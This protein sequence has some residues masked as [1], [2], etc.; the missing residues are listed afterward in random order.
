MELFASLAR[1]KSFTKLNLQHAYQQLTLEESSKPLTTINTHRGLFH[2]NRLPFGVSSTPGI[3]QRTMDSL[4]QGLSHVTVYLDDIL[5]TGETEEQHLEN[6]ETVLH[7]LETAGLRLK[8]F[9]CTFMAPEIEYLGHKISP[10]GLY[11]TP[12]NIKAIC[13]APKPESVSE[14]KSF[15]GLLSYY[16]WFLPNASS[17]LTPLYSLLQSNKKWAWSSKEQAAFD[18]AKGILQSTSLLVHYD[19]TKPLIL[20]CDTSPYGVGAVLS[21]MMEDGSEKPV[22]FASRTLTPAEKNYSQLEKETI[23]YGVKKFLTYLCGRHFT[24]FSDHQPLRR[25]FN[26]SKGI[27][28]MAASRIQRWALTLSAYEY[29]IAYRPEKEHANA[30]ALSRLPLPHQTDVP[31]PEDLLLLLDTTSL[32]TTEQIRTWTEKEPVLS[33]VRR[34]ILIGWPEHDV[35]NDFIPFRRRK[36]EL[37]VLDGCVLWGTRVVVPPPGREAVMEELHEIH[38]GIVKMKSLARS[39]MWWPNM[40]AQLEARVKACEECQARRP[41]PA[42]APLHPGNGH[43]SHGQGFIWTIQDHSMAKCS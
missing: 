30:D 33:R 29:S 19:P 14:L 39:Y 5:I 22:A 12:D 36:D 27:P 23:V 34:F 2:Y 3:F 26:E 8:Q 35:R 32:V 4:L 18:T 10:Q 16:S 11:L 42:V 15:L 7:K 21:Y 9:K 25:L 41:P 20:A 1:G 17:T 37:S 38:P 31:V 28:A 43:P 24:I 13:N 40:N 6:L